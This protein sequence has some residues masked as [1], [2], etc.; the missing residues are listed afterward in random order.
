MRDLVYELKHLAQQHREG[1]YA[2]QANR[3]DMLQLFGTQLVQEGGYIHMH[4]HELKGRH[5]NTL[6][7]L[8]TEQQL[9]PATLK[10]RLSVLR[11]WAKH[12]GNP[13][14]LKPT[15]AAYGVPKRQTVARVSKAKALPTEALIKVKDPYVRMSLQLQRAF[16]LR[17]EESIKMK[18][19]QADQGDR[20]VLQGSWCKGGRP[21]EIPIRTLAQR[22]VLD[23]AKAL[24]KMKH[25]ALIPPTKRY[26]DQLRCYEGQTRRAGLDHLHGLRHAWAH[27]R[28]LELTGFACPVRG[29]PMREAMTPE[30][31]HRDAEARAI[32]AGELGHGRLEIAAVYLDT[33]A[34][35]A[36]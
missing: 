8:W 25:A 4:A 22:E 16:G 29:G 5:I 23:K 19:W 27:D 24:V 6:L 2:T 36:S 33:N 30:Q 3:Q 28:Y 20:L 17:R 11:W 34:L 13:G 7:R 21:R 31:V 35:R 1:S 12:V 14:V 15:N 32:I 9:S 26:V 10:N 18:P